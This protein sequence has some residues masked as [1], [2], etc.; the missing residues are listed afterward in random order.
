MKE[1]KSTVKDP[2]CGMDFDPTAALHTERDGKT[3]Y[4]CSDHCLQEFLHTPAGATVR[5]KSEGWC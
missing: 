4:F 5:G 1:P 3:Y 2:V